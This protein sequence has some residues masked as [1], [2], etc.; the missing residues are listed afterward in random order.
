MARRRS[1][2]SENCTWHLHVLIPVI[3]TFL[4][5]SRY[6]SPTALQIASRYLPFR[7]AR[8]LTGTAERKLWGISSA[9]YFPYDFRT[10]DNR[11]W[12][13][14][15]ESR[16]RYASSCVTLQKAAR[17]SLIAGQRKPSVHWDAHTTF[18]DMPARLLNN[19]NS[20]SNNNRLVDVTEYTT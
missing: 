16:T 12:R 7:A 20:N 4:S 18:D 9:R 5:Y 3:S 14:S 13:K 2:G 8:A 6:R 10:D 19:I 1:P 17:A 11:P 15:M